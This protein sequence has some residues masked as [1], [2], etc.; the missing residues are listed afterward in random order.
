FGVRGENGRCVAD[1]VDREGDQLYVG[2]GDS[3]I[4]K[5]PHMRAHHGTRAVAIGVNEVSDPDVAAEG[6]AIE[7][8]AGLA[9]ELEIG[10]LAEYLEG[11]GVD[12]RG[13]QPGEDD[14]TAEPH[15]ALRVCFCAAMNPDTSS[16]TSPKAAV[17]ARLSN[18]PG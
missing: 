6:R 7:G 17:T 8:L 16:N 9:G 12:A 13:E 15:A 14:E 3:L 4:L 11:L 1:R 2:S 18:A 10:D 5:L